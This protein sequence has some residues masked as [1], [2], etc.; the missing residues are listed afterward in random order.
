[1]IVRFGFAPRAEGLTPEQAAK[2]WRGTHGGL[3]VGLPGLRRYVQNHMVIRSGRPL[4]PH[5]GFD[6]FAE[7][8]FDSV[9][10]ME[11]AFASSVYQQTIIDDEEKLIWRDRFSKAVTERQ[12]R[13]DGDASDECVKLITLL[14]AHPARSR[15]S[16]ID[17]LVGPYAE[18]VA[19]LQPLRHEQ[20]IAI[21]DGIQAFDAADEIWFA[22]ANAALAYVNSAAGDYA[23]SNLAGFVLGRERVIARPVLI[24][25]P[26]LP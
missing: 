14:R 10:A 19:G 5:P 4:L 11:A 2:H 23:G 1:V 9:S 18:A 26:R 25:G 12:V 22:N 13:V 21:R 6:I 15:E 16:F 8:E 7:T 20:L 17:A 24:A 3:A